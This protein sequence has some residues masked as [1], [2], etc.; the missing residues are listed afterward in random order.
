ML[1]LLF[2]FFLLLIFF[3][4]PLL[5]LTSSFLFSLYPFLFFFYLPTNTLHFISFLLIALIPGL[6]FFTAQLYQNYRV[7]WAG[8]LQLKP[9]IVQV[10]SS[11]RSSCRIESLIYTNCDFSSLW[12]FPLVDLQIVTHLSHPI[13]CIL[14][15]FAF[16]TTASLGT[17]LLAPW[18]LSAHLVIL[19]AE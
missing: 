6:H 14:I 1:N 18:I 3:P 11:L 8:S 16:T 4:P 13:I 10:F 12:A 5:F 2:I 19:P 17:E 15:P 9:G 7:N